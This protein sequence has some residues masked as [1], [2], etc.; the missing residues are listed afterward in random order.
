M[1]K[2]LMAGFLLA[3]APLAGLAAQNWDATF[4]ET[5][6]GHR[7]GNPDAAT[8]LIAFVSYSCPHCAQFEVQSDAPLRLQYIQPGTVNMEVRNVIRNPLDIAAAL[9]AQ[10]GPENRFWGNH[11]ALLRA[12]EE[13]MEVAV[14]ASPAQRARWTTGT[15]GSRMRAIASDL[16][17]YDL[18]E[19]RGYSRPE[20][21]RCLN[22]ETTARALVAQMEADREQW[23][24]SGTPSFVVNGTLQEGVHDWAS[25]RPRLATAGQ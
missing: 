21:D 2:A 22:D 16:D 13:W 10:C 23:A 12:Q 20:L 17:F 9:A 8:K 25:L 18:L 15:F 5:P 1:R 3:V 11:R 19:R 14:N 6:T 7:L 4:V 24:I